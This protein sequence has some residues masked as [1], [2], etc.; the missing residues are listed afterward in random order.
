[1]MALA[2]LKARFATHARSPTLE[3]VDTGFALVGLRTVFVFPADGVWLRRENRSGRP[4]PRL[5]AQLR[6][7]CA[8][9][10]AADLHHPMAVPGRS[11]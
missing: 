4:C 11:R 9:Q 10:P 3:G 6:Q 5:T 7:R 1:M 8:Q 2:G